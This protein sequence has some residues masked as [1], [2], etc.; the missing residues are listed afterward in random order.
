[1]S[2]YA[3]LGQVV[4]LCLA[5]APA[6]LALVFALARIASRPLDVWF[7]VLLRYWCQPRRFVWRSVRTQEAQLYP[8]LLGEMEAGAAGRRESEDQ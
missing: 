6:L 8:D 2:G 5:L 7:V 4:R 3:P 1:L